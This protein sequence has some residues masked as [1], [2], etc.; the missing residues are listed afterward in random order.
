M[1]RLRKCNTCACKCYVEIVELL[2]GFNNMKTSSKG[3]HGRYCECDCEVCSNSMVR[4][5]TTKQNQFLGLGDMWSSI[6]C[7]VLDFNDWHNPDCLRGHC[8]DYGLDMLITCPC[9]EDNFFKKLMQWNV[10]GWK[11]LISVFNMIYYNVLSILIF[12]VS[13]LKVVVIW[14]ISGSQ[15]F[16][17]PRK[18]DFLTKYQIFH[19]FDCKVGRKLSQVMWFECFKILTH[20]NYAIC[21]YRREGWWKC[22]KMLWYF[23]IPKDY[24]TFIIFETLKQTMTQLPL[25][26][27]STRGLNYQ[28]NWF[29]IMLLTSSISNIEFV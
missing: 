5:F 21:I 1:Q 22:L 28:K 12:K 3:I 27:L 17:I 8:G 15:T 19:R 25:C 10:N 26:S 7:H 20:R 16:K 13:P 4:Q 9:E 18:Y 29:I 2:Q 14:F 24:N 23:E 11:S 6:L